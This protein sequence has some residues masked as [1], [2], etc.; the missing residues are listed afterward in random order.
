MLVMLLVRWMDQ[1][2]LLLPEAYRS[3][4][5]LGF[6]IPAQGVALKML[7]SMGAVVPDGVNPP[8]NL[9]AEVEVRP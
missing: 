1:S 5:L 2:L 9:L 6:A 7:L 3:K 4:N 8:S